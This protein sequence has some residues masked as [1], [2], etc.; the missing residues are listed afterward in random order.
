LGSLTQ[1][2]GSAIVFT[3]LDADM[4]GPF[5]TVQFD[6]QGPI[7]SFL[8]FLKTLTTRV[9]RWYIFYQKFQFG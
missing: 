3:A 4:F 1:I 8:I 5:K 9:A 2:N 6:F 7:L